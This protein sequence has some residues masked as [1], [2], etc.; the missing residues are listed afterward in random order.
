MSNIR[1]KQERHRAKIIETALRLMADRTFDELSVSDICKAAGISIGSF[2]HYFSRKSDLLV[3]LLGLVDDYLEEHVFPL[4]TREDEFEN[5]TIVV[6]GFVA[7][8]TEN[9]LERSRLIT[10]TEPYSTDLSGAL[11]PINR[12]LNLIFERGQAKG[13]FTRDYPPEKLTDYFLIAL[14]GVIADWTRHN[15]A[16]SLSEKADGF[17]ALFLRSIRA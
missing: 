9:G 13:Q 1:Q 6:D 3:G 2:Y 7:H 12:E 8:V 11:R 17:M 16:Y 15:G 5:L 14:R 10:G 4:L